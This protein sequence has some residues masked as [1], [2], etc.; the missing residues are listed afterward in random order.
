MRTWHRMVHKETSRTCINENVFNVYSPSHL[1]RYKLDRFVEMIGN[2]SYLSF[3][4]LTFFLCFSDK[5]NNYKV[6]LLYISGNWEW[7]KKNN[8]LIAWGHPIAMS[9]RHLLHTSCN[10]YFIFLPQYRW[11]NKEERTNEWKKINRAK[12]FMVDI[13]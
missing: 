2:R 4:Y 8:W 12:T 13:E 1:K 3:L 5:I 6:R 7:K 10:I 9:I 11:T